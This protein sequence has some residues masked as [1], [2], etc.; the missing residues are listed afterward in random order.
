M[1]KFKELLEKL[2]E[3]ETKQY[4]IPSVINTFSIIVWNKKQN[5]PATND[6]IDFLVNRDDDNGQLFLAWNKVIVTEEDKGQV[7]IHIDSGEED[8]YEIRYM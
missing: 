3:K 7:Y 1:E 6:E 2:N 4:T 8:D 5:R